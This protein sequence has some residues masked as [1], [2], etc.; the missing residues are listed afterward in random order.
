M[1][2][3]GGRSNEQLADATSREGWRNSDR[4]GRPVHEQPAGGS[5]AGGDRAQ[6]GGHEDSGDAGRR[7]ALLVVGTPIGNLGDLTPRASE[8]LAGADVVACEDTRRT[9][10][11][12]SAAGIPLAGKRLLAVHEHNEAERAG[13]IARL[14]AAGHRVALVTDAG[15]PAISDPGE[16]VVAAVAAAGLPVEVVPGPSAVVTALAASGLPS[17]RF[18][19]E[20]F[21]PRKGTPRRRR[22]DDVAGEQRTVVFYEA[23]HR[24]RATVDDLLATCG[25]D[26]RVALARELTKLHE[27]VWRGTLAGAAAQLAAV[28]PRGEFVIVLEGAPAATEATDDDIERALTAHLGAGDDKRTSVAAVALELDVAKRRVY[29]AVLRVTHE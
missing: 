10:A 12:L 14:I 6:G 16:R 28:E 7:P 15:M 5:R 23:P 21:L 19:F 3:P 11:L 9:R 8:A 24:A 26:R 18:V 22:L 2:G 20:G 13:H 29:E 25:P 4:P 17:A 1:T 27:D